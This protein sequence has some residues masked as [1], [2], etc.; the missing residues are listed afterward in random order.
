LAEAIRNANSRGLGASPLR[1]YLEGGEY[2]I[3]ASNDPANPS[4]PEIA[5]TIHFYGQQTRLWLNTRGAT[6]TQIVV[7]PGAV[8]ELHHV[9]VRMQ[10]GV[11]RA[12]LNRGQL[13]IFDSRFSAGLGEGGGIENH[14]MLTIS[15]TAFIGNQY[16]ST[17]DR[18]GAILNAGALTVTCGLFEA[19]RAERGGAIFNAFSGSA[20]IT[21][22]AFANNVANGGGAIFNDGGTVAAAGNWW[23]DATPRIESLYLGT[24]TITDGVTV[25]PLADGDPT[26]GADCAPLPPMAIPIILPPTPTPAGEGPASLINDVRMP[27]DLVDRG[28]Q[29]DVEIPQ[30]PGA[31]DTSAYMLGRILINVFLVEST[32]TGNNP[33]TGAAA[34][35]WTTTEVNNVITRIDT[36]LAWWRTTATNYGIGANDLQFQVVYH[37][38]FNASASIV[39]INGVEPIWLRAGDQEG[40]WIGRVMQNLGYAGNPTWPNYLYDVRAYN[41]A[42]RQAAGV[43]WAFSVFI[44][45]SSNDADDM[46]ADEYFAY[47]YLNGP[48]M[49]MTYGNNGWGINR[50]NMVMAHEMSHIFGAGDEYASSNCTRTQQFGYLVIPNANCENPNTIGLENSIMRSST[51][52]QIAYNANQTSTSNRQAIGWRDTNSNGVMDPIDTLTTSLT[53]YSPNPTTQTSLTYSNQQVTTTPWRYNGLN[54]WTT[55]VG[56]TYRATNINTIQGVSYRVNAG[57]W[58]AA[59][60]TTLP[61]GNESEGYQFTATV[62][63]GSNQIQTRAVDR[64]GYFYLSPVD[65]VVVNAAVPG[66]PNQIAPV[67]SITV[68]QPTFSWSRDAA[69]A[70]Y[71]IFIGFGDGTQLIRMTLNAG[72]VCGASTCNYTPALDLSSNYYI[73][74]IAGINSGGTYGPWSGRSFQVNIVPGPVT[75]TGPSGAFNGRTPTFTWNRERDSLVYGI[76][77]GNGAG[78]T[79]LRAWPEAATVCNATTCSFT[80]SLDLS[81]DYYVWWIMGYN[82]AGEGGPG[83]GDGFQVTVLPGAVTPTGPSGSITT[84]SPTFTWNRERDSVVYGIWVG[85]D[86]GTAYNAWLLARDVCNATTCSVSPALDMDAGYYNFW[87]GGHSLGGG[88]PYTYLSFNVAIVPGA[89]TLISPSGSTSNRRPTL[90]WQRNRDGV[91]YGVYLSNIATGATIVQEWRPATDLCTGQTCTRPLT[92]DLAPGNYRWGVGAYSPGGGGPWT[93][94]DFTV[95]P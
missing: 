37:T 33:V 69:A 65:T 79:M 71:D 89:T 45:D 3:P 68:R 43:D 32:V 61:W 22:S 55:N 92:A 24:D 20:D 40:Q 70:S 18:G 49:V 31:Q 6:P 90:T 95:T 67:G 74:W 57:A 80:P 94:V 76:W 1:V 75:Q 34:E 84:R 42:Q 10:A 16:R 36:A 58:Q 28:D 85:N 91:T 59:T 60:G 21:Q 44:A 12:I 15:R 78:E 17:N 52:Q 27:P 23:Q 51:N 77:V 86:L 54:Q 38:P 56:L 82:P 81:S 41:H 35:Q 13:T 5:T 72:T 14:G 19:G 11:G 8:V 64:F 9:D 47:A 7:A 26:Q 63:S 29:L 25:E 88:G 4:L 83:R 66:T 87:I 39:T 2:F 48:F 46:F 62:G 53:P 50:M 30:A 93:Y 73:W